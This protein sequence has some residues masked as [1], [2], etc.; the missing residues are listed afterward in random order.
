MTMIA[1]YGPNA[2]RTLTGADAKA[3]I[4][5][6]KELNWVANSM[7]G[8]T[9]MKDVKNKAKPSQQST[10]HSSRASSLGSSEDKSANVFQDILVTLLVMMRPTLTLA[11]E[12]NACNNSFGAIDEDLLAAASDPV[13]LYAASAIIAR[14]S[15]AINDAP[16]IPTVALSFKTQDMIS[17]ADRYAVGFLV[18]QMKTKL[19]HTFLSNIPALNLELKELFGYITS[20][21]IDVASLR[22]HVEDDVSHARSFHALESSESIQ[23]SLSSLEER[24]T[25][26]ESRL[27]DA[28]NLKRKEGELMESQQAEILKIQQRSKELKKELNLL[29]QKESELSSASATSKDYLAKHDMTVKDL[30]I[31]H[32]FLKKTSSQLRSQQQSAKKLKKISRMCVLR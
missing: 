27:S 21:N 13:T 18:K 32:T 17:E 11:A 7:N 16:P 20:K 24:L 14:N 25:D 5:S 10:S 26:V 23:P 30:T 22:E 8:T 2:V 19:L 29:E 9:D 6:G 31:S 1:F 4:R 15:E 12:P 28:V 3:S